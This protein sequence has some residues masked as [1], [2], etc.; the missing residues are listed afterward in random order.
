MIAAESQAGTT[1]ELDAIVAALSAASCCSPS[2]GFDVSDK[3]KGG[4]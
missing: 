3:R 2:S 4:A 1:F